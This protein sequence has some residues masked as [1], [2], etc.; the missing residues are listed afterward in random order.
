MTKGDKWEVKNHITHQYNQCLSPE[1]HD[2]SKLHW[3]LIYKEKEEK[4]YRFCGNENICVQGVQFGNIPLEPY[5]KAG[6]GIG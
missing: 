1:I 3:T 5:F 2:K 4:S 6:L